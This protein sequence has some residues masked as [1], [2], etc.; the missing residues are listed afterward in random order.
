MQNTDPERMN[1]M[2]EFVKSDGG[3]ASYDDEVVVVLRVRGA[4]RIDRSELY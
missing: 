2:H 3:A 4:N 1:S